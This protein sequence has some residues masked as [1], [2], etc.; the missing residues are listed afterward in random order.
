MK[1]K[2]SLQKPTD[3]W[4]MDFDTEEIS[5]DMSELS[6]LMSEGKETNVQDMTYPQALQYILEEGPM[7]GVHVILQ[8]DKPGNI[9]FEGDYC[10][11]IVN[12]FKHR[13]ILKSENQLLTLLRFSHDMDVESLSDDAEHLRAY[14]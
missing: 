2:M 5:M 12:K 6:D 13:I 4:D 9:L 10:E 7:Q 11:D 3:S 1:R 14:Y 8:V